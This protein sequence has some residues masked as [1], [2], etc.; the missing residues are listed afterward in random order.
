MSVGSKSSQ[1][2]STA[3]AL[4]RLRAC[5]WLFSFVPLP[6]LWKRNQENHNPDREPFSDEW[7]WDNSRNHF[8]SH[9]QHEKGASESCWELSPSAGCSRDCTAERGTAGIG[10]ELGCPWTFVSRRISRSYPGVRFRQTCVL[11]R[12]KPVKEIWITR[13]KILR[14]SHY[15]ISAWLQ[16]GTAAGSWPG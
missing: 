2:C 3:T 6:A 7:G 4:F 5:L 9:S 10:G 12:R 16:S 11:E 1:G 8:L 13:E 14:I 15:S